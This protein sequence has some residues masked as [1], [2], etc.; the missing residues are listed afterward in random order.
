MSDLPRVSVVLV[1]TDA[2]SRLA[3][4]LMS[5]AQQD[6]PSDCL[7]ILHVAPAS[8]PIPEALRRSFPQVVQHSAPEG[9]AAAALCNLGAQK[10]S[11]QFVVFLAA[12]VRLDAQC[13]REMVAA[14]SEPDIGAV[15]AV[16]LDEHGQRVVFACPALDFTGHA[17]SVAYRAGAA[18]NLPEHNEAI[19]F[20][21]RSAMLAE[22]QRF[23]Q[24]G[25]FDEAFQAGGEDVDLGWRLWSAG[26]RVVLAP[27][28]RAYKPLASGKKIPR[29]VVAAGESDALRVIT[30]NYAEDNLLR[31]LRG[32]AAA[33]R[34][35]AGA[36]DG[37]GDLR[38]GSDDG[39]PAE[40]EDL[41]PPALRGQA[42][43]WAR[44][45]AVQAQRKRPDAEILP[46]FRRPWKLNGAEQPAVLRGA[47]AMGVLELFAD[48]PRRVLV[49]SPDI[50]PY[51]GLPTVGSSLRAWG[52]GHG[53]RCKGH[54]VLFSMPLAT[55]KNRQVELP[56]EV[57]RLAWEPGN[58]EK[59]IHEADP[60]MVLVSGWPIMPVIPT[61]A[62]EVPL[63][64][65]QH[66]PHL[67]ER[68]FQG[69]GT[70]TN[71]AR[72]KMLAMH[73]A[74]FF[75]CAGYKQ[76][77]YFRAWL[78]R[79]GWT[80]QESAELS[81][82]IPISLDPELP[83]KVPGSE[84]TFVYGGIFLPWQDPSMGLTVLGQALL[85]YGRGRL[86]L[87][88]G[89]HPTLPI[90]PGL[91]EPL[92]QK[93]KNNPHVAVP[94]IIPHN[95]LIE[96]YIRAQVAL[97]VMKRNPERE[98]AFTTRTVEYLWC[99]LPVIYH[100]YAELSDYIRG[101]EAGWVVNP[102]DPAALRAVLDTVF[103]QP[104]EVARRSR[105]AQRLVRER[106]TW[107]KT[108]DALDAFVRRPQMRLHPAPPVTLGVVVQ[109]FRMLVW[110]AGTV[111]RERG[112]AALARDLWRFAQRQFQAA[113]GRKAS[114]ETA[115]R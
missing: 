9:A 56:P 36:P 92:V 23:L 106:L 7:E 82:A 50:L 10:A 52:L 100:D 75:T 12:G 68:Q 8:R 87:F 69:Y 43:L 33:P 71:N 112:A 31:V 65:D 94:G 55:L 3:E 6:Y 57:L 34:A 46:L 47:K 25:G 19:L 41:L 84:L 91:F 74:D 64:L 44:R 35:P 26:Y 38:R 40:L 54:E 104:D 58:I 79:A 102:E 4:S 63:V 80:E 17:Q 28:A 113:F 5:V 115:A 39:L 11:G 37:A 27:R 77:P 105:N 16:V 73:Q 67:L 89:R 30:K 114:K 78:L 95:E 29:S 88:S 2:R 96:H 76:L 21:S 53:L 32:L 60:D 51:P 62:L 49:I 108:I 1:P 101:Y 83:E 18:A 20:A 22:R 42:D 13:V 85:D 110:I 107:D 48:M 90:D 72:E 15:G 99:G 98:L 14:A 45:R 24:V 66:G 81:A 109:R 103:T 70:E 97:D 111:L 61:A 93:L 59:L 86:L